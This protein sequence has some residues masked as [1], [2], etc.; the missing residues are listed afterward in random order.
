MTGHMAPRTC[1][2]EEA[3]ALLS[4]NDTLAFGLGPAIPDAFLRALGEREDWTDLVIGGALLLDYYTLFTRPGVSYRCG[5]FGPAERILQAEGHRVELV[6]S[7]FRQFAPTLARF[8]PRVLCAQAAPAAGGAVSLSLHFGGTRDELLAAGRDPGRLLVVEVNPHLPRTHSHRPYD[9]TIPLDAI[10]VLIEADGVPYALEDTPPSEAERAIAEHALAYVR[11]GSTLQT[12][13]GAIPSIVASLL[14]TRDGGDYGI[15]SEMFTTGL[16][17]IHQ[18]GKVTNAR[19][20]QF[21]G[22]SVTTFALGTP[23]LYEWL[24][25]NEEV[26]FLP[27]DVVNDPT[28]IGNNHHL[29]SINGALQVD[30]YGQVVADSIGGKQISGVGGHED[31]VAAADLHLDSHSLIC[32]TS[33]ATV[34]GVVQS[35]ILPHLPEGSV[36][37]TPRHHTNVVVTEHGV[38]EL[39]GLTVSERAHALADLADPEFRPTLHAAAET[40]GR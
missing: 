37:S 16:M 23:A 12:G 2:P 24:D 29:V 4:P 26:A 7:G 36:I 21:D 9:N 6:P 31:F 34:G 11:D 18:A 35:R 38:A 20:G 39:A 8:A 22:Y 40:L 15:H 25:D 17:D 32:M 28:V 1:S 33:T 14:A 30:L 5:F 27:V 19:K 3:A 10:D 13:I